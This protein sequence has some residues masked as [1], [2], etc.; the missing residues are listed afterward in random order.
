MTASQLIKE[1]KSLEDNV[2]SGKRQPIMGW[3]CGYIPEEI[4]MAFGFIPYRVRGAP[5]LTSKAS[6]LMPGNL[7]PHILSCLEVALQDKY[8]FLNGIII[9]N[10]SD[11]MRRL[12]DAW[13]RYID[14]PFV[15][16]L[17]VP[18]I[19]NGRS[20]EYFSNV[21]LWLIEAIEKHFGL[22]FSEESL[23]K[24]IGVCNETRELLSQLYEIKKRNGSSLTNNIL[25][26]IFKLSVSVPKEEFNKYLQSY[27]N[28]S[29]DTLSE[30][31]DSSPTVLITG[32]F[33]DQSELSNIINEAGGKIVYEDIC[34]RGRYYEDKVNIVDP[35]LLS[36]A[37]RYLSRAQCARMIDSERR[38]NHILDI[39]KKQ[40][41]DAVIYYALKF[42]DTYL[43]E[44]PLLR[45]WLTNKGIPVLFI[46]GECRFGH[47][48]QLKA[49]IQA[50]FETLMRLWE[51][52]YD[53][54]RS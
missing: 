17:D 18:R 7:N 26:E 41:I 46:E 43:F 34:T 19:I 29:N 45:E 32:S 14:T 21:L 22:N 38:F 20:E 25:S 16:M 47:L 11:A 54:C 1:L 27:I 48:G 24:A 31:K 5:I 37:K 42:D 44:F 33:Y 40:N 15:Y 35:P 30:G 36:L 28:N 51:G 4:P 12:Y 9:A 10:T 2:L 49:R 6:G 8:R 3:T 53:Y 13:Q 52:R 23:R 50:F 39:I